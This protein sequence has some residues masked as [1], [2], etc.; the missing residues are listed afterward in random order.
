M[1]TDALRRLDD[2]VARI[3]RDAYF[4]AG[5]TD[6]L[7]YVWFDGDIPRYVGEG[8]EGCSVVHWRDWTVQPE[9]DLYFV[10]HKDTMWRALAAS[11]VTHAV[12]CEIERLLIATFGMM[13]NGGLLLNKDPGKT[14]R[15]S[16]D[17]I[18]KLALKRPAKAFPVP[19]GTPFKTG[20]QAV[21][22]WHEAHRALKNGQGW[23]PSDWIIR[24]LFT[25][26]PR[27]NGPASVEKL[28]FYRDGMTV[29][30][31]TE[32]RRL[33]SKLKKR[34]PRSVQSDLHWDTQHCFIEVVP[35]SAGRT[36]A[37]GR[38]CGREMSAAA[39]AHS[40]R[41]DIPQRLLDE[42]IRSRR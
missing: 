16:S 34:T 35:P 38:V 31:L 17:G 42:I 25:T 11:N 2:L 29:A 9:K 27:V 15:K 28:S 10:A 6:H 12:A 7:V 14:V 8:D 20:G 36:E 1:M 18:D 4:D 30:E 40:R 22:H 5:P 26:M 41:A 33:Y 37:D 23:F 39:H 21:R 24:V 32:A 3:S 19:P 13:K